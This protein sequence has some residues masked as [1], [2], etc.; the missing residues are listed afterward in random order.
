MLGLSMSLVGLGIRECLLRYS[1]YS[2][3]FIFQLMWF[4]IEKEADAVHLGGS[5]LLVIQLGFL[6]RGLRRVKRVL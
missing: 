6:L 2:I 1:I 3:A 4:W 5:I